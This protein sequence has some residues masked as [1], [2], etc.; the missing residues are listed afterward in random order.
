M[1][2]SYNWLQKYIEDKLP[3]PKKLAELL[4]KHSFEVEE[5]KRKDNDFILDIDIRP[6]RAGDCFSHIG[7]ARECAAII[8]SK[9]KSL[10]K[11]LQEDKDFQAKDLV[12]VDVRENACL[13]YT[14]R[15]L[16][17]IKV[18]ESPEWLKEKLNVCGLQSINNIVDA[19]NYVMLEMGQP[20]HAFDLSK[21]KEK[22]IIVRFAKEGEK[23]ISLDNQE[24]NLNRKILVIADEKS[25]IAIA[26]IK[27]GKGPEIDSET[28][29]LVLESANFDSKTIRNASRFLK[30]K[31]DASFRFE[32]GLDVNLTEKAI[33]RAAQLI[34]EITKCRI[35][36]GVVDFYPRKILPKV[37]GLKIEKVKSL[38]G[39]DISQK[40][41]I[42]ILKRL[43]F[44]V[45]EE[46]EGAIKVEV[47][48]S[49]I[50]VS[51][52]EDLIEDIGRIYG[53]ENI[54][55][56]LPKADLAS[57]KRNLNVFWE[58][59]TK[60]I[61]KE[62]GF[63]EVYN[64]SFVN[65]EQVDVFGYKQSILFE[66][67]NPLSQNQKYLCPS[68]IANLLKNVKD[69]FRYFDSFNIF[70]IGKV[71][72]K[73]EEKRAL[74]GLI[75]QK[76]GQESFYSLK[77]VIDVLFEKMGITDYYYDDYQATPEESNISIWNIKKSA[78]IK[79]NDKE[80]GFIGYISNNILKL[81]GINGQVV[82]FD[83]DFEKLQQ[84][85]IE[86][87]EYQP[88]CPYPSAV[89]DLS[90][91]VPEEVRVIEILNIINRVG[92]ELISDVDLFDIYENDDDQRK[93]L[94]FH[95]IYQA[96][97]RTLSS[98]EIDQLQNKIVE[99]LE[100]NLNWE[101]RK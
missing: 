42:H 46:M 101:I 86:E 95:I 24:F 47:P 49:R 89:R 41:I 4:S 23:I 14:A 53:Y 51:L 77:G 90:I 67:E 79:I 18:G 29:T 39:I 12:K 100:K 69:N 50:D 9:F 10:E 25:P 58:D 73:P 75:A 65:Q 15:V 17:D 54:P 57:P 68:L 63:T 7:V 31:T 98:E 56:V 26:G 87:H 19:V 22:K 27:G 35:A 60:D 8:K 70:E 45:L 85:T 88:I 36:S 92:G 72:K 62:N 30:L 82:M 13:R 83:I 43:D 97:D 37:V 6:N 84:L 71:S 94:A 20:L 2:F 21:L 11:D 33:N 74:T 34:Q 76:K 55:I 32:H 1:I 64:Y 52:P 28:N 3:E 91:L 66:L 61:L 80:V 81:L 96:Q 99:N 44:K 48:T 40:E 16:T 5:V 93:S 78:E 38:L 59:F